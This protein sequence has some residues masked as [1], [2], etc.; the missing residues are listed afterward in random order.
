MR[1][2]TVRKVWSTSINPIVHAIEGAAITQEKELDMLRMR[3]LANIEAFRYG[4]ATMADWQELVALC[5]IAE[6]MAKGGVGVEVESVCM[7]ATSHLVE[8]AQRFERTG[9][10]GA[11]GPALQCWQDLFEFHD[12]QRTSVSRS[13]YERYIRLAMARSN[14]NSRTTVDVDAILKGV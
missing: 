11:T 2:R 1:K 8:S 3:E 4:R 10:M 5:N 7:Q 9:K 13:E 14:S 6:A 12:L